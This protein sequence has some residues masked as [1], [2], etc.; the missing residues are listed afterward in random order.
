VIG[1]RPQVFV[2][3]RADALI[4]LLERGFSPRA[5]CR[6][7]GLSYDTYWRW[8]RLDGT[9]DE[10]TQFAQRVR[11]AASVA[12][13][14]ITV[15]GDGTIRSR[16][17]KPRHIDEFQRQ[18]FFENVRGGRSLRAS[19]RRAGILY[20]TI[21]S[22]L[23]WGGYDG[24][25]PDAPERNPVPEWERRPECVEFVRDLKQVLSERNGQTV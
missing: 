16:G 20:T 25:V 17:R 6:K 21:C 2:G 19:S 5:A 13:H 22:W 11:E 15:D 7:L 1:K 8:M 9:D 4:A 3:D 14:R 12:P 10:Y 24:E 23:R 18:E